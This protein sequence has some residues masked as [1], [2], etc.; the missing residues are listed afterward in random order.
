M[1]LQRCVFRL[2]VFLK[3]IKNLL[4]LERLKIF[5]LVPPDTKKY[6]YHPEKK[7]IPC[8]KSRSR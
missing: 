2:L 7:V 1:K 5:V 3:P 4:H 8:R 6:K